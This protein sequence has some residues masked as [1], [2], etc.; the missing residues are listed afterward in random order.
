MFVPVA[1]LIL[2]DDCRYGIF[3]FDYELK[4]GGK[5][6]KLLFILWYVT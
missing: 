5:R 6:N 2:Q 4:D 1:D 3:D